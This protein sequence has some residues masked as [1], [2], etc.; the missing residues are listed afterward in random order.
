MCFWRTLLLSIKVIV[1][2]G[3]VLYLESQSW[4]E[5]GPMFNTEHEVNK[6]LQNAGTSVPEWTV[7]PTFLRR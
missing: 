4:V 2:D 5:L 3:S 1:L 7:V 6:F